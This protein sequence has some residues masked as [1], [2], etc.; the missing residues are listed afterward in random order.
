MDTCFGFWSSH[1]HLLAGQHDITRDCNCRAFGSNWRLASYA[2]EGFS[3][4]SASLGSVFTAWPLYVWRSYREAFKFCT[5]GGTPLYCTLPLPRRRGG[6]IRASADLARRRRKWKSTT[7]WFKP[8]MLQTHNMSCYAMLETSVGTMH[9]WWSTRTD[10]L[11]LPQ[12]FCH[13]EPLVAS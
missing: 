1:R 6:G 8:T 11:L 9:V 10:K 13:S 5:K 12:Q 3:A 7:N 2:F 4:E